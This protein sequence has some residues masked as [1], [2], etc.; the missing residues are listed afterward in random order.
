MAYLGHDDLW[1]P[2]HLA[3][4]VSAI[5]AGTADVVHSLML[6]IFGPPDYAVRLWGAPDWTGDEDKYTLPPSCVMHRREVVAEVGEWIHSH[7]LWTGSGFDWLLRVY[8]QGKRFQSVPQFTV[9]KFVAGDRPNVYQ[10]RPTHEQADYAHRIQHQPDFLAQEMLKL[11]L[12]FAEKGK[13]V[14]PLLDVG[15]RR[16]PGDYAKM[17][18]ERIGLPPLSIEAPP[19]EQPIYQDYDLLRLLNYKQDVTPVASRIN[20]FQYRELSRNGILL[21]SGW[22]NCHESE[23]GERFRVGIPGTE[24]VITRPDGLVR[25][26]LIDIM[27]SQPGQVI[28]LQAEDGTI[29][30]R[31][32]LAGRQTCVVELPLTAGESAVFRLYP[33][34]PTSETQTTLLLRLYQVGWQTGEVSSAVAERLRR[35]IDELVLFR[36]TSLRYW[37]R[38][39]RQGI[40]AYRNG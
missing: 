10:E 8:Q 20:L 39:L 40:R 22:Y 37:L 32:T 5:E 2:L 27:P 15:I 19:V 29:I 14:M 16:K 24:I 35:N 1:H 4:L 33:D 13:A 9:F 17:R 12:A 21:G 28:Q 23:W 30:E 7:L 34:T 3:G 11:L 26:L 36:R 31:L 25:H 18:I 6:G 38:R